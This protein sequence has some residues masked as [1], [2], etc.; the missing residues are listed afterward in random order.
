MCPG[1]YTAARDE[2][3]VNS[4][5]VDEQARVARRQAGALRQGAISSH[6]KQH[7]PPKRMSPCEE[8]QV[9]RRAVRRGAWGSGKMGEEEGAVKGSER[10]TKREVI[11]G[12]GEAEVRVLAGLRRP[13]QGCP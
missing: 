1:L 13:H 9:G 7:T 6:Q 12:R 3:G 4:A 2:R 10:K 11:E 8:R 5:A